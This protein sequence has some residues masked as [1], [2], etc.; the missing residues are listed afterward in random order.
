MALFRCNLWYSTTEVMTVNAIATYEPHLPVRDWERIRPFVV[1]VVE[2]VESQLPYSLAAL[3]N[4]VTHHV[5][6]CTNT[7]GVA[8]R[9]GE[10]FRRDVIGAAIA[11]MPTAQSSTRGRRR[12]ILLRVGEALGVIPVAPPLP[13]LAAASPS[14][15]YTADE[16]DEVVRWANLQND[17]DQPSA[18]ALVALGFGA[19]LPTRDLAMV[20]AS[21]VAADARWIRVSGREVPVLD[22]WADELATLA[23]RVS[24]TTATLFRPGT[25][26]SKNVVTVF[27][28]RAFAS[29]MRPSTQRMRATWLVHHLSIGTPMQ[30]PL[31]AAG[32]QSMDALVRYERFLPPAITA[33]EDTWR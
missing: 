5:D 29:G 16:V 7:A 2:Q 11:M 24:D 19:G 13:P 1:S 3:L 22:D 21:D 25:S 17:K 31:A 14:A 20:K 27:V 18:L 10:I 12:S 15:P 9:P 26:W 4:A 32:L 33:H 23:H 30:D 6:W 8:L 28:A